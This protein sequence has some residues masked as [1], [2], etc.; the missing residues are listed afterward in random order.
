M[1]GSLIVAAVGI[2]CILI[3]VYAARGQKRML[4]QRAGAA[5][6]TVVKT[7]TR[8]LWLWVGV[9]CLI[10]SIIGAVGALNR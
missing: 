2:V 8:T 6:A 3:G 5:S 9:V 7:I 10:V 1:L 4:E